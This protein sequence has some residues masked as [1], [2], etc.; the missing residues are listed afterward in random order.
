MSRSPWRPGSR[1]YFLPLFFLIRLS[2]VDWPQWR[3]ERDGRCFPRFP[4]GKRVLTQP[5]LS[6]ILFLLG[7]S[8]F[9]LSGRPGTRSS[10]F[11][12]YFKRPTQ[13]SGHGRK[14]KFRFDLLCFQIEV[15]VLFEH[16]PRRLPS[17]AS[18]R[19]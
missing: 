5:L 17:V 18:E 13:T 15:L 4:V 1:L 2:S 11:S 7:S 16:V 10:F 9:G 3:S 14:V 12:F 6:Q 8:W 19:G